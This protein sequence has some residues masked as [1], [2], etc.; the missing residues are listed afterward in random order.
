MKHHQ[1]V[2]CRFQSRARRRITNCHL[3]C[4]RTPPSSK[5]PKGDLPASDAQPRLSEPHFPSEKVFCS[6]DAMLPLVTLP[7]RTH[8][9]VAASGLHRI[10]PFPIACSWQIIL[11]PT[12]A[13]RTAR[14]NDSPR[15]TWLGISNISPRLPNPSHA[16][17]KSTHQ[18]L[19]C[20]CLCVVTCPITTRSSR[21]ILRQQSTLDQSIRT[22]TA[23][24]QHQRRA[25]MS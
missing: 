12:A 5:Y 25:Q 4:M 20:R 9:S 2:L 15:K 13:Q 21:A 22:A 3:S 19:C 18:P 24:V 17:H 1:P 16:C 11:T 8:C 23:L 14:V 6:P 10:T 7:P